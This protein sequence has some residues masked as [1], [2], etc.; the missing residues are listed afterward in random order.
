[1]D[2]NSSQKIIA[3]EQ[4]KEK[5]LR[6]LEAQRQLYSVAKKLFIFQLVLSVPI[7]ILT[8]FLAMAFPPLKGWVA[9]WGIFISILCKALLTP[10]QKKL[11]T[12]AA[13]IQE[14][15]DCDVLGIKWN[16]IKVGQ[17]PAPELIKKYSDKYRS[18]KMPTVRDWYPIEVADLPFY[19]G[20]V[21]CQRSNC[22]WDASLRRQYANIVV[23]GLV[24]ICVIAIVLALKKNLGLVDFVLNVIIPFFPAILFGH[25]QYHDHKET[26]NRLDSIRAH[27]E[28]LW[29]DILSGSL[30]KKRLEEKTRCLQNEIY[31]NRRNSPLV[32]D[33]IFKMLRN[34]YEK[35][36]NHAASEYVSEAKE[37][38]KLT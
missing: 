23:T 1:M 10:W 35:Q 24:I 25:Q 12:D 5:Q 18:E 16:E 38:M 33:K 28:S 30:S 3:I 11:Q 2:K 19:I 8:A 20:K 29:Q 36:M 17:Y 9:I 21:I 31:D 37:K 26:A 22:W 6:R 13:K 32:F 14:T 7:A 15:F 4:N 34:D 27:F